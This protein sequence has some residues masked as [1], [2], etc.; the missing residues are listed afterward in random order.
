MK[1]NE[2]KELYVW[3]EDSC[4]KGALLDL[5]IKNNNKMVQEDSKESKQSLCSTWFYAQ[6]YMASWVTQSITL[7]APKHC[8]VWPSG[9]KY[10]QTQSNKTS[11]GPTT[12]LL[13]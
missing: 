7:M 4:V 11:L 2:G 13:D 6:N 3:P 12:K 5:K 8:Q 10:F 1:W 9:H